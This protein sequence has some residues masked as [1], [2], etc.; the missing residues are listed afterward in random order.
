M[1]KNIEGTG[2]G[3]ALVKKLA[4]L[5]HGS[6]QLETEKEKGSTFTVS[7]PLKAIQ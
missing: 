3:L 6:I 5:Y 4:E 7:L 1:Q 2:L